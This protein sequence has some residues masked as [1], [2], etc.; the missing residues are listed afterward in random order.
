M[1]PYKELF[2]VC[3]T[4]YY[5]KF[6]TRPIFDE[7]PMQAHF[8]QK[9]FKK[10]LSLDAV[11]LIVSNITIIQFLNVFSF[12]KKKYTCV[13][14]NPT[15]PILRVYPKVVASI[16]GRAL[17]ESQYNIGKNIYIKKGG[18]AYIPTY[19]L[20]HFFLLQESGVFWPQH[21]I[22]LNTNCWKWLFNECNLYLI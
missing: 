3:S 13:S 21:F 9:S 12:L 17:S 11:V 1:L 2:N 4:F 14:T 7:D 6:V 8:Y 10:I 16:F 22:Q 18:F 19:L 5:L 15:N 20:T